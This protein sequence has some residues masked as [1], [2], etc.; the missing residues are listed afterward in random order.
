MMTIMIQNAIDNFAENIES[1][2]YEEVLIKNQVLTIAIS[3]ETDELTLRGYADRIRDGML[4]YI[5]Q[6]E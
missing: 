2:V 6:N 3:A 5:I 4:S 1:P